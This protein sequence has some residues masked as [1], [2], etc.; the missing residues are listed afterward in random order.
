MDFSCGFS[1]YRPS[2]DYRIS[3]FK[4][5]FPGSGKANSD[6]VFIILGIG[7]D[8]AMREPS[9]R[10]LFGQRVRFVRE[11]RALT[12]AQLSERI[13]VTEQYVGMIER[14]LASP[15]FGVI[16][17]LCQALAADPASLFL[18]PGQDAQGDGQE[19]RAILN[20]SPDGALDLEN[21]A[22]HLGY[23]ERVLNG[24]KTFYSV[25]IRRMFGYS[26]RSGDDLPDLFVVHVHPEDRE[27]VHDWEHHLHDGR[28]PVNCC[29][30]FG[31]ADGEV[32]TGFCQ[33]ALDRDGD[34]APLLAYGILIDVTGLIDAAAP[35]NGRR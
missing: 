27:R 5:F 25:S 31:R 23:W 26:G 15:S 8:L 34:G 3:N 21:F 17:S 24:G 13:G 32:R 1:L 18:P 16:E 9:L 28:E 4:D 20:L 11:R 30:R 6:F 12:Q 7:T 33:A 10:S 35:D 14:G 19:D 29:F 2:F 22:V